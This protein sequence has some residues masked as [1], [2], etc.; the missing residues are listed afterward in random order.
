MS[1]S[2][3]RLLSFDSTY[4]WEMI[5]NAYLKY[6]FI[7]KAEGRGRGREG[8]IKL[9]M[10]LFAFQMTTTVRCYQ[11][12]ARARNSIHVHQ[13]DGSSPSTWSVLCCFPQCIRRN[14]EGKWNS[15]N[16]DSEMGFRCQKCQY[17][18]LN[19]A[20]RSISSSCLYRFL[21]IQKNISVEFFI[22]DFPFWI[23]CKG[24]REQLDDWEDYSLED[25]SRNRTQKR[26]WGSVNRGHQ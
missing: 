7:W 8:D 13:M 25:Q 11:V 16:P 3:L 9:S 23:L 18:R 24:V 26:V 1:S 4:I 21:L 10:Y 19:V 2:P 17:W 14:S 12:E 22:I 6:F 20:H 5:N 15:K